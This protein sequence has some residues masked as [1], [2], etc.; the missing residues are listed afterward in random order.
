MDFATGKQHDLIRDKARAFC[1][2]EIRPYIREWD[3]TG[4]FPHQIV[5]KLGEQGF[6]GLCIPETEGGCGSDHLS[7]GLVC[8]ELERADT[9][10][11]VFISVHLGL[12]S[13]ALLQWG[14]DEQKQRYLHAQAKGEKLAAFALTEPEAGSDVAALQTR[15]HFKNGVYCINGEKSWI[16][17]ADIADHFLVFASIEPS[18]GKRGITAFFIERNT[19]GLQTAS[20]D[21]KLGGRAGNTGRLFLQ[22]VQVEENNRLGA[23][24]E[25]FKIAMTAL[26]NGRFTVAADAVGLIEACL[27]ASISFSK[28]RETFGQPIGKHQLIQQK[29][30]DMVA[31]RDIGRLLYYQVGWLRDNSTRCTREVGLAKWINCR[32]AFAAADD[33]VQIHGARGYSDEYPVER[34]LRNARGARIYEGT[35]E[36]NQILQAEYA[37][38]YRQDK[39]L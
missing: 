38:G 20:I 13:L 23:E 3:R 8:E 29:I 21:H 32:N 27:G 14:T 4:V 22:N 1:D 10:F 7:L 16:G 15:A 19:P 34:Y 5:Q 36:I 9:A 18:L 2:Q 39:L 11:R 12:N 17:F 31:N 24:G 6:L 28:Q 33:A 25:G 26:D 35:E 30:A 37:L